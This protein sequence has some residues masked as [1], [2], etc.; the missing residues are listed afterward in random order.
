MAG[1]KFIK[2]AFLNFISER[3]SLKHQ[4]VLQLSPQLFIFIEVNTVDTITNLSSI[5]EQTLTYKHR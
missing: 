1:V 5:P 4:N 3:L 2:A